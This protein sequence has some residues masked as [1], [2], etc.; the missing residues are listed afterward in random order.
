MRQDL[1]KEL[2]RIEENHWWHL[3]KQSVVFQM[4]KKF[5]QKG[6][7][8]DIGAGTGKILSLL[9]KKGWQIY[10][11]E[12]EKQAIKLAKK[13]RVSL[14]SVDLESQ[15]I[16]YKDNS[17]DLVLLLDVLEHV[18]NQQH[19]LAEI[20]RLLQRNGVAIISV[21]AYQWLFCYWDEMLRHKR[22]YTKKSLKKVLQ[23]QD[24]NFLFLSYFNSLL[25]LPAI[26][27]RFVK[28]IINSRQDVSDFQSTPLSF[29]S[30][31][32]IKSYFYLERLWLKKFSL[33]FGLS[34]MAVV[35]KKSET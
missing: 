24:F 5:A 31:P 23:N 2:Y 17:F 34:V 12:G 29:I 14:V 15:K 13:R 20:K 32:I 8:L 16:P 21:P 1:Y 28:R 4:I 22:R 26:L 19:L 33:P 3:H 11:I 35:Y 18:D 10:G 9:K 7:V 27:V 30:V 6:K 25:L